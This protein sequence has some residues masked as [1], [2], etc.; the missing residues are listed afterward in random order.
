MD[1]SE[2]SDPDIAAIAAAVVCRAG[3]LA[4]IGRVNTT[5]A[6]VNSDVD[7]LLGKA[8]REQL[9]PVYTEV[10]GLVCCMVPDIF[11]SMWTGL[12]FAGEG[13]DCCWLGLRLGSFLMKTAYHAN[14]M[15]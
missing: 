11:A 2:T 1:T 5:I 7:A 12:T 3:P 9:M 6:S 4:V 8:S 10:K 13:F 14:Q 15:L